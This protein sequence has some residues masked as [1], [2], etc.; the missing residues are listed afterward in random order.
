MS[1]AIS[2]GRKTKLTPL[3]KGRAGMSLA[4][5]LVLP[6]TAVAAPDCSQASAVY[7]DRDGAYELR[8]TP[9]YSEAAAANNRFKLK[10]LKTPIEL[11]GYVMPS[12]DPERSIGILMFK[13]PGG[14][15]TGADLDACTVWRGAVYGANAKGEID[16][17][18][19]E[20]A[21]AAENVFLPGLGPA[22]RHSQIWGNDKATVAPWDVL[23]FKGCAK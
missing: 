16:N 4:F 1:L 14:D 3:V 10:V 9:I 11:D 13:C 23:A 12:D 7:A 19:P 22:I 6:A 15:V 5:L 18:Q 8:F 2:T 21:A 20:P 17:L